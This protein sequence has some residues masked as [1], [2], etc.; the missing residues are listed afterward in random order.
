MKNA[1]LSKVAFYLS[2]VVVVLSAVVSLGGMN[3][4]LAGTQ[5]ILV[6]IVLAVWALFLKE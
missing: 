2:I 4:W 6:A 3:L 1:M 5:W